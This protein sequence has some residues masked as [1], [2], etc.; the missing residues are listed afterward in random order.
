MVTAGGSRGSDL[1][2]A[3][4]RRS[5]DAG[6]VRA[7]PRTAERAAPSPAVSEAEG[8]EGP[9]RKE[10]AAAR[11]QG[12]QLEGGRPRGTADGIKK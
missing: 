3:C 8:A 12:R 10:A 9:R 1:D 2:P 11:S 4:G 5:A 7:G 6:G